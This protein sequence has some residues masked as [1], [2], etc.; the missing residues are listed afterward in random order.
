MSGVA[1]ALLDSATADRLLRLVDSR[2]WLED[3]LA[4]LTYHRIADPAVVDGR[5]PGLVSATPSEFARHV[6]I[7]TDRFHPVTIEDVLAAIAGEHRLPPRAL[8][9]TFDDAVD[10][11]RVNAL[12]A[13]K[14]AGA[15]AV[16]FVPT[17]YVDARDAYFWWDA[18]HAAIAMAE[19]VD[20][21]ATPVGLLRL[22]DE[23]D[24]LRAYR[25]LRDHCLELSAEDATELASAV[26]LD[27][28]VTPP[29]ASVMDWE[30]LRVLDCHGIRCCPHTRTHPHLD[31]LSLEQVSEEVR[32]SLDD[33]RNQLGSVVPAFAYPAGRVT[34]EVARVVAE[35]GIEAAF[36]TQ[37]GSNRL[38]EADPMM[39]RRVNVGRR[40]GLGGLRMQILPIADRF[41]RG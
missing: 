18:L 10:D 7:L 19:D 13:L 40:F 25:R 23:G 20:E 1:R 37:R 29:T 41:L 21:V 6:R 22:T 2:G 14:D 3:R 11:F 34:P 27:L 15:P 39:L 4:V 28:G 24:R 17:R 33:I 26:C 36:T 32:G 31:K 12:P 9:F 16:V 8:L 38:G 35:A 5:Y 30:T